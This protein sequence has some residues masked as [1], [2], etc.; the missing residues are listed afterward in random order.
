MLFLDFFTTSEFLFVFFHA[1]G[2]V[3]KVSSDVYT[4][5]VLVKHPVKRYRVCFYCFLRLVKNGI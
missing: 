1:M 4:F 3:D 2:K 5:G